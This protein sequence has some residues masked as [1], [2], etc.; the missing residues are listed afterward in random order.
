MKVAMRS[1]PSPASTHLGKL[2][3][4]R[5]RSIF[6]MLV[7][8]AI[9][10]GACSQ[11]EETE[12]QPV[13]TQ[14]IGTLVSIPTDTQ[15]PTETSQPEKATI[16]ASPEVPDTGE[17]K[18]AEDELAATVMAAG[19]AMILESDTSPDGAWRAEVLRYDCVPVGETDELAYEQLLLVEWS[20]NEGTEVANQLQYCGGLG[21]FGLSILNWSID[22][23]YLYYNQSRQG[24]PDGSCAPWNPPITRYDTSSGQ[25]ELLGPGIFSPDMNKLVVWDDDEIMVWDI[26]GEEAGKVEIFDPET[27]IITTAWSPD[28]QSFIYLQNENRCPPYGS[29]TLVQVNLPVLDQAL[30]LETQNPVFSDLRWENSERIDL[31]DSDGNI[32][33]F[34]LESG[35]L[36][37]S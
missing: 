16:V 10:L 34:Y 36:I 32:W 1:L 29:S 27:A 3:S 33:F 14:S 8:G 31:F 35:E 7:L 13:T 26:N 25:N 20:S 24:V 28:S 6:I 17:T 18:S 37:P 12:T 30:I 22:S 23:R 21:A 2:K 9:L 15:A 19:E 11:T 5:S 4:I